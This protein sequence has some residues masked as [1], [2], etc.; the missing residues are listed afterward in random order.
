MHRRTFFSLAAILL[1]P[2]AVFAQ[3]KRPLDH[4][5][6][7]IWKNIENESLSHDGLWVL[8][9]LE[10][11]DGDAETKVHGL[12]TD[13]VYSIPRARS[14]QFLADSRFVVSFDLTTGGF[15]RVE[16]VKS[17]AVPEKAG[18]WLAYLLETEVEEEEE[19]EEEAGEGQEEPEQE[20][21]DAGSTLVVRDL[22]DGT[23]RRFDH[24]TEY[25]FGSDGRYLALSGQTAATWRTR[26]RVVAAMPT[27]CSQ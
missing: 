5:A 27:A 8:Y 24:V 19:P 14:A 13:V 10:L 2:F 1:L 20:E 11:Q 26:R 18:G 9:S 4:D 7:D 3:A 16:Q 25:A 23:E 17:F 15:F 6:Y 21:K 22:S 12:G